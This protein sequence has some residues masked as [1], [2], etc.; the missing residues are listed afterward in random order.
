MANIAK[1]TTIDN[2]RSYLAS[3]K[4]ELAT[5][6]PG[7]LNIARFERTVITAVQK[8]PLLMECTPASILGSCFIAAQLG[9]EPNTPLG[10]CYFIPYRNSKNN[11]RECQFQM[12]Y[13]GYADLVH[14]SGLVR[15]MYMRCVHTT[16]T[17]EYELGL[18]PMMKHI[19]DPDFNG[20]LQDRAT[21]LGAYAVAELLNGGRQFYY[22]PRNEI[23]AVRRISKARDGEAW[24]NYYGAMAM[25][26]AFIRLA[27]LLPCS[28]ELA[29]A[30]KWDADASGETAV[31]DDLL[32]AA[33]PEDAELVESPTRR[34]GG[35]ALQDVVSS[36]PAKAIPPGGADEGPEKCPGCGLI[37]MERRER[38]RNCA[39]NFLTGEPGP[40]PQTEQPPPPPPAGKPA[41]GKQRPPAPQPQEQPPLRLGEDGKHL[42]PYRALGEVFKEV[43]PGGLM[44]PEG[45][46]DADKADWFDG[47]ARPSFP[48]LQTLCQENGV[49]PDQERALLEAWKA[50]QRAERPA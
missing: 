16:D 22:M 9:L 4:G 1:R 35:A 44:M 27:K 30:L 38:C 48:H 29:D 2:L 34:D 26:S 7:Q 41:R 37:N 18:D 11:T 20:D 49:T 40:A 23:D 45:T 47:F 17:F 31:I 42:R 15:S 36:P 14:R 3:R 21:I 43:F 33:S 12:G 39:Y 10:H 5:A 50:A 13:R 24:T 6:L 32:P 25:K 8:N 46:T 28:I 19:P